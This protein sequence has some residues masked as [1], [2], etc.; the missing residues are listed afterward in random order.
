[1]AQTRLQK[2]TNNLDDANK[3]YTMPERVAIEIEY[4]AAVKEANGE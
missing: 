3:E 1:M 2:A 4:N